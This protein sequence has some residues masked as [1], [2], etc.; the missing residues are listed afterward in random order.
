LEP[1][2]PIRLGVPPLAVIACL[3][4]VAAA[5]SPAAADP[6]P[7]A[8]PQAPAVAPDPAPEAAA[9][10]PAPSTGEQHRS[11]AGQAPATTALPAQGGQSTPPAA[12]STSAPPR[13]QRSSTRKRHHA[14]GQ[15]AG[16]QTASAFR[17]KSLFPAE[18][19]AGDSPSHEVLLAAGALLAL[20]LASGSLVSV[21]SRAMKGHLR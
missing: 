10:T 13:V 12:T 19:D 1:H 2:A 17:F 16:T 5:P 6:Q 4:T 20:V 18:S 15:V 14:S 21:S 8:A 3:V 7:D 11:P 9:E